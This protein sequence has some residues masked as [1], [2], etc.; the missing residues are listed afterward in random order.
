MYPVFIKMGIRISVT[1]RGEIR[2]GPNNALQALAV[3]QAS[4]RNQQREQVCGIIAAPCGASLCN[5]S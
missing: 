3:A 1:S 2:A 5:A 4:R